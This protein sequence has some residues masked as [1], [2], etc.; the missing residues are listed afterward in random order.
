MEA[1]RA[2]R[3]IA[4]LWDQEIVPRL[5]EYIRIPCRSPHFDRD[6]EAHGYI[7]QAVQL[8]AGWCK[9]QPIAGMTTEI[10]RLPGRT[11]LLYLDIPG[12]APGTVLLYGHLDKQP[13]MTGWREGLGPWEPVIEGDKLYGRGGADDGYAVFASAAAVLALREQGARHARC[14]AM[15]ECCEESGS[16]DLPAYLEAL[17][18]RIGAVDLVIGLDS[19]CGNYA[20]LWLTTSLR[21][22]AAGTLRV[23]VLTEGVHSGDASGIVPSSFRIARSLLDRIEDPSSGRILPPEF[24]C[25]IPPERLEQARA[26]GA[27]LGESVCRKYPFAGATSPMVADPAE[28][29]LN[30]TWRPFLSVVGANGLPPIA[31]AGNVLRPYT[32]LKLSLRLPP[33]VDAAQASRDLKRILEADP[34]CRAKVGFEPDQGASGWNAPPCAAWLLEAAH[35]ASQSVFGKRAAMMG[36]GGTIPFMG[37]LGKH[38]PQAQ[39]VITGVLGPS[40]NAHGPNEFIHVA[41]A[42]GLTACVAQVLAHHAARSA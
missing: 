38:Y 31:S 16:Y 37:M 10:V 21:G 5:M 39:F 17:A 1:D 12:D 11:P 15:I 22:I 20:Q 9:H 32:E 23:E 36:E 19:G 40:S 33:L 42:K 2:Q 35:N 4:A 13:E 27:M 24:H 41:Y 28:A 14:V 34:P 18:P 6:W 3:S 8:A 30:R 25:D 29:V 7:E 26:V